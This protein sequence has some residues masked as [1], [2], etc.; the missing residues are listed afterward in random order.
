[1]HNALA[2]DPAGHHNALQANTFDQVQVLWIKSAR[3]YQAG[4][5]ANIIGDREGRLLSFRPPQ[6]LLFPQ[7]ISICLTAFHF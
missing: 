7:E 6:E 3:S 4:F 1:M 5:I 2:L